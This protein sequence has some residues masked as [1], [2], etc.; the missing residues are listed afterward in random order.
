MILEGGYFAEDAI[1]EENEGPV[2]GAIRSE[3]DYEEER[4]E[5]VPK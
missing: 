3:Y 2:E 1:I 4:M 5:K